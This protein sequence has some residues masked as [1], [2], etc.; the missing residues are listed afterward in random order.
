MDGGLPMARDPAGRHVLVS[1]VMSRAPLLLRA[2]MRLEPAVELLVDHGYSGAP[3]ITERGHLRGMLHALDVAV[4]HLLPADERLARVGP[5]R[6]ILVGEVCRGAVTIP[7]SSTM[8]EAAEAMRIHGTDRLAVVEEVG[9][10][11]GVVTG[12]DLLRTLARRGDLLREIVDEQIVTLDVP[13]VRAAVDFSGVVLL[14]GVVDS[15][16]TRARVVRAI[17]ELEGVTEVDELL[18]VIGPSRS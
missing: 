9:R 2:D 3:V 17:G 18:Q 10:V 8:H 4:M 15:N 14:T 12:H 6:H 16:A 13:H 7:A 1:Q 11:V 5:I